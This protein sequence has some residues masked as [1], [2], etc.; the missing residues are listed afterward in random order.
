LAA[1]QT[2]LFGVLEA[3]WPAPRSGPSPARYLLLAAIHRIC[4]PGPKTEVADWYGRTILHSLWGIPPE[5]FTSQAFWDAFEK[6]LPEH[7]DPLATGDDDPLDRAQLRL[8]D[9]WNDKQMV[10]RRLLAYDTTNFY[11]Y[12]ASNNTRNDLAQR[13]HNKQGRHNLRQVGLSYVLDG[14]NG[15]SLCHHVYRGNVADGNFPSRCLACW[16][17]WIAA[18][19]RAT[20]SLWCWTKVPQLWPTRWNYRRRVWAGSQPC[21]GIKLR[22]PSVS[23]PWNSCRSAVVRSPMCVRQPK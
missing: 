9:L 5:R 18:R 2:G 23:A 22:R 20:R 17:C 16:A 11:T 7:L 3:L 4:Q 6:I 10:S 1:E 13:G 8:L 15:L 21:R 14:E 12:I 19:S